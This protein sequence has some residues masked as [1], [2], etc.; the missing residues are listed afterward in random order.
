MS[1]YGINKWN[2]T[3]NTTFEV[4]N[5]ELECLRKSA[6]VHK[7]ARKHLQQILAKSPEI[8]YTEICETVEHKVNELF[9]S[10]EL[11]GETLQLRSLGTNK[12]KGMGFPVGISA[13]HVAA[14]DSANIGDKRKLSKND[15]VKIDFGTHYDG[16]IIDSAFSVYFDNKFDNLAEATHEATMSTIKMVGPDTYISELSENIKEVIESYEVEIDGVTYPV[17]PVK[18]L[19]GHNIKQNT[20][21]GGSLILC[22][23]STDPSY[24]NQRIEENTIYAIETFASTGK[25]FIVEDYNLESNHFMAS[26]FNSQPKLVFDISKKALQYVKKERGTLPFA[27]RWAYANLSNSKT[28]AGLNELA[29]KNII[30]RYPPLVDVKGSYTSQYEHTIYVSDKSVENLSVSDDY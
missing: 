17:K 8:S 4:T 30:K 23:P 21:H 7:N 28:M 16:Y 20:I 29:N 6:I 1:L 5:Y 11:I 13:N 2:T 18:N 26:D 15:I 25:G 9:Q 24:K 27:S 12:K 22:H 3:D 19:G 10:L 14:H